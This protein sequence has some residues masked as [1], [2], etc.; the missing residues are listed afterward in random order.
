M[1]QLCP[2]CHQTVSDE[3]TVCPHCNYVF[4]TDSDWI[5][6]RKQYYSRMNRVYLLGF[7]L[8]FSAIGYWLLES[9]GF[10]TP[11]WV[12]GGVFAVVWLAGFV[13]F[14]VYLRKGEN[15]HAWIGS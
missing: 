11:N 9:R 15:I 13:Y 2:R 1:V 14:C 4:P 7:A 3:D 5:K 12:T 10:F 8:I 6:E